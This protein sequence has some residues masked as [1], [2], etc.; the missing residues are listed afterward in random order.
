MR[1]TK[2]DLILPH[3]H[4]TDLDSI[5]KSARVTGKMRKLAL[6]LLALWP[7]LA[8]SDP[9][10][11]TA[12]Q[13][14]LVDSTTGQILYQYND[15]ELMHPSSM[16]KIMTTYLAF[17]G[18]KSGKMSLNDRFATSEK[19]WKMGGSRMFLN[20]GD[21]PTIDE[22]L[23][24][25]VVQSGND[26]CIVMA[27]GMSGD[28]EVFVGKMNSM[29]RK[30]GMTQTNFTNA[31]GW[32]DPDNL[33]TAKDLSKLAIA[34]MNNFPNL[35][36]Y[37]QIQKF[38]YGNISQSNRN[39]LIG[40]MGVDGIKT[41]HTDAGGYGIVLSALQKDRRLVAVINGL[42]SDKARAIEGEK[43]LNYGFNGF[44]KVNLLKSDKMLAKSK[45]FYGELPEVSLSVKDNVQILTSN[46]N[47]KITCNIAYKDGVTA[48]ISL[49]QKLGIINCKIDNIYDSEMKYDLVAVKDV[50]K[51]NFIQK[52]W[53]NIE[54]L[55]S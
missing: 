49:G 33:S 51:A 29:A 10:T 3:T 44:T 18:L 23:K 7:T 24:G 21:T 40:K 34:L 36:Q 15:T 31:S 45:I 54:R 5:E 20:Y 39:L 25:I 19:A 50:K 52:I 28:E 42:P 41:G 48:P 26:A 47:E 32:P 27:E 9:Y 16:T 22:L 46:P 17:D 43:I 2:N 12:K 37:H 35:Y 4:L 30:L 38:T 1:D 14:I 11:T 6:Y 53:Q 13:A 8:F 55:I